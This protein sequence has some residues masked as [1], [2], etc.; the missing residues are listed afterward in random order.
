MVTWCRKL[1]LLLVLAA[2]PLQGIATTASVLLCHMGDAEA[3]PHM[4]HTQDGH[5]H[6]VNHDGHNGHDNDG[7]PGTHALGHSCFHHFASALPVVMPLPSV[8]GFQVRAFGSHTLHD[9]FVPDRPQRP[10]LA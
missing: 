8:P 4:M 2:M 9:L 5:G 3:A 1:V 7:S 10:P 6:D